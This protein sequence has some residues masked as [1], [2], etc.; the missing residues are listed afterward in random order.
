MS[1]VEFTLY[2]H[3]PPSEQW[4][5]IGLALA[6]GVGRWDGPRLVGVPRDT[7]YDI[8]E[9]PGAHLT[10]EGVLGVRPAKFVLPKQG[11]VADSLVVLALNDCAYRTRLIAWA[12]LPLP[13]TAKFDRDVIDLAPSDDA[14]EWIQ[15]LDIGIAPG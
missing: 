10:D 2:D 12:P 7:V 4:H 6:Q 1:G 14:H 9:C 8:V 3:A 15:L 11:D 5:R 13:I